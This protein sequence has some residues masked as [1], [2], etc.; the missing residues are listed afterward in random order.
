MN[1]VL[2]L[3][4]FDIRIGVRL[5]DNRGQHQCDYGTYACPHFQRYGM[6]SVITHPSFGINN[7]GRITNNIALLELDRR[8]EFDDTIKPICLPF[9]RSTPN[10]YTPLI[11]SGWGTTSMRR[12]RS[13]KRAVKVQLE[14]CP[15][16]YANQFCGKKG[17]RRACNGDLGGPLMYRTQNNIMVL[18]GIA[19]E[20]D[21]LAQTGVFIQVR[22]FEDWIRGIIWT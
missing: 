22:Q 9:G 11:A 3:L 15:Y 5:A 13:I 2:L 10:D 18:E 12:G 1:M 7:E 21:D 16:R 17:N 19:T 20:C 6:K 8:I 4:C 14:S